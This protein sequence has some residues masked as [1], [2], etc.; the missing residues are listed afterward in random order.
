MGSSYIIVGYFGG[1]DLTGLRFV[2][3][4]DTVSGSLVR[5]L[6]CYFSVITLVFSDGTKIT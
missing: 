5:T 3:C 4:G 6:R 1:N 2:R